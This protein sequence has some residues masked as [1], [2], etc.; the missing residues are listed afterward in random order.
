M[1][2][3]LFDYKETWIIIKKHLEKNT[4][5]INFNNK[6]KK[7]AAKIY[8]KNIDYLNNNYEHIFLYSLYSHHLIFIEIAITYTDPKTI[9]LLL[10]LLKLNKEELNS[11]FLYHACE[12]NPNIQTIIYLIKEIKLDPNFCNIEEPG[13]NCLITACRKNSNLE[14]TK[15]LIQ[16]CNVDMNFINKRNEN[17]MFAS[18]ENHNLE[19]LKYLIN[20]CKMNVGYCSENCKTLL[21]K[22]ISTN[23]YI[24][25]KYLSDTHRSFFCGRYL[26]LETLIPENEDF[27][28]IIKLLLDKFGIC[29]FNKI[30]TTDFIDVFLPQIKNYNSFNHILKLTICT[31]YNTFSSRKIS[32]YMISCINPLMIDKSNRA[33]LTLKNPYLMEFK[34]F[35]SYVNK[36]QCDVSINDLLIPC[37]KIEFVIPRLD[38]TRTN[39]Q[40][41]FINNGIKYYGN[42]NIVFDCIIFLKQLL[43]DN[44]ADIDFTQDIVLGGIVSK[45]VM[46]LYIESCHTGKFDIN[47]IESSQMI[48]FLKFIDQYPTLVLSINKI[49]YEILKYFDT[50]YCVKWY[51][52]D[53]IVMMI[54][55]Y[56]LKLM[57]LDKHNKMMLAN[58]SI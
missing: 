55:R 54:M 12:H 4:S 34:E 37:D 2:K 5:I 11:K 43:T 1:V 10:N 57:Y 53:F 56:G 39:E 58:E 51:E 50:H 22:A 24:K 26:S 16:Y 17:C 3:E 33:E 9:K 38:Y 23:K 25:I 19:I 6:E 8:H 45:E 52:E 14:I 29:I 42:R 47:E 46:N 21:S 40:I 7:F 49:E 41:L 18:C 31:Q 35:Y 15:Y 28:K 48:P 36:L 13:D 27:T 44:D 30:C 32:S 20:E